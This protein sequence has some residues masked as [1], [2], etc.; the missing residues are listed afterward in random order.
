M[1]TETERIASKVR[2][3][4]KDIWID[5]SVREMRC[6]LK[7]VGIMGGFFDDVDE[8]ARWA[9]KMTL[10]SEGVWMSVNPVVPELLARRVNRC[11]RGHAGASDRD[12]PRR[13]LLLFDFD[14]NRLSGISATD[15]EHEAAIRVASKAA[16]FLSKQG[17]DLVTVDSGNGAHVLVPVD[18]PNDDKTTN[19]IK[20][21]MAVLASK[22]NT[23]EVHL[24]MT[25][26]NLSRPTK[27][28]GTW[29]RKGDS[30]EDRPHRQSRILEVYRS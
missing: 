23:E 28:P 13:R 4:L 11:G 1:S 26:F 10:K 22:F 2:K 12:I 9:A 27:V 29:A 15:E 20:R 17:W 8:F 5:G 6:A 18:L 24:D 19:E 21:V 14:S 3:A 16:R 7:P 30:T 25:T